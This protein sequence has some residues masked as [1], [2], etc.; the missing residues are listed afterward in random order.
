MTKSSQATIFVQLLPGCC[1]SN[2]YTW[3]LYVSVMTRLL[4]D[5]LCI[6]VTFMHNGCWV[7]YY[8][9]HSLRWH[10]C[11]TI[12]QTT[13]LLWIMSSSWF[14]SILNLTE[15]DR[16]GKV[17]LQFWLHFFSTALCFSNV[18]SNHLHKKRHSLIAGICLTF[19]HSAFQMCPQTTCLRGGIVTLIAFFTFLHCAFSNVSSNCLPLRMQSHIGCICFVF[20]TVHFQMYL[21]TTCLRRGIVTLVAFVWLFSTVRFQMSPQIVCL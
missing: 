10:I 14:D 16:R 5:G 6:K 4:K 18:A 15:L 13:W 19:L 12:N 21:Q 11:L 9:K 8:E 17:T 2:R 20:S 1:N 7:N 3:A